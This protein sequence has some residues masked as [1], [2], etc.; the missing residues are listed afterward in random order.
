MIDYVI[1]QV[2]LT[3]A[4]KYSVTTHLVLSFRNSEVLHAGYLPFCEVRTYRK[5]SKLNFYKFGNF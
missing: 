4:C 2:K 1:Q 3:I 5:I